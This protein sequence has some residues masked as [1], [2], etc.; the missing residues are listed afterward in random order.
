MREI[1]FRF[2]YSSENRIIY[3]SS[4]IENIEPTG[5]NEAIK[6]LQEDS[7]FIVMQYTGLKDKNGKEIYEEDILSFNLNT[8]YG[9][10]EKKGVVCCKNLSNCGIEF[11]PL[12]IDKM[13]FF[14]LFVEAKQIKILG[15]IYEN[16]ELLEEK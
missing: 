5:I 9:F 7:D 1:K 4:E 16:L 15:N 12:T 10:I 14:D 2:W 8:R 11:L 3:D 6:E 13:N